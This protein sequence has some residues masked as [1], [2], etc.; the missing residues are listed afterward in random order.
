M[1][2]YFFFYFSLLI[3]GLFFKETKLLTLESGK[4]TYLFIVFCAM[5]IL[6]GWRS[7]DMCYDIREYTNFFNLFARIPLKTPVE[8]EYYMEYGFYLFCKLISLCGGTSRT[9]LIVSSGIVAFC[10]C[11]FIYRHADNVL[12]SVFLVLS[13][14]YFYTSF[15]ILRNYMAI[16][17]LLIAYDYLEK[18]KFVWFVVWVVIA[19]QF[20]TIAYVFL[21]LY[22]VAK[23]K[24]NVIN[25]C[26]VLG[27]GMLSTIYVKAIAT[28]I[29]GTIGMYEGYISGVNSWW[30][31]Q[32]N[33]GIK[34]AAMYVVIFGIC[35]LAYINRKNRKDVDKYFAFVLIVTIFSIMY[36][37][38]NIMIR[39]IVMMLPLYAIAIPKLL[40]K[41][42]CISPNNQVLYTFGIVLVGIMYHTYMIMNNWQNI[43]P[44][45]FG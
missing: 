37:N 25:T 29:S 45:Q 34:T 43:V 10:I 32:Y 23:I 2:I 3:I 18:Q 7:I 21:F 14:P 28:A 30:I 27:I 36:T 26:F 44:Y 17:I 12:F 39:L 40:N 9:M 1:L 6:G 42:D 33:G 4:R 20:H 19:A 13:F 11:R 35:V 16:S 15:D 41:N 8:Y 24:W 38:S 22:P 31:G 5:T